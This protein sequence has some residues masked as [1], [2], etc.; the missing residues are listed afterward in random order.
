MLQGIVN[1][2]FATA[3]RLEAQIN[4]MEAKVAAQVVSQMSKSLVPFTQDE[5]HAAFAKRAADRMVEVEKKVAQIRISDVF[6]LKISIMQDG[7]LSAG[8]TWEDPAQA[9]QMAEML[10]ELGSKMGGA[11]QLAGAGAQARQISE[12]EFN[13][14]KE[15]GQIPQ[16]MTWQQVMADVQA[17]AKALLPLYQEMSKANQK[18][19]ESLPAPSQDSQEV[20]SYLQT[21][22]SHM[23]RNYQLFMP[24]KPPQGDDPMAAMM[25]MQEQVRPEKLYKVSVLASNKPGSGA[26]VIFEQKPTFNN[27][28]GKAKDASSISQQGG[29]MVKMETPGGPTLQSGSFIRANGGYLVLEL[30]DVLREPGVYQGLMQMIR[31]GKAVIAENGAMSMVADSDHYDVAAQVKVVLIG[32]P[33]LKMMLNQYDE[34][35]A[36]FFRATAEFESSLKIGAEAI[37]G[38][39]KFM[40]AMVEQ[41]GGKIYDFARGAVAGLFELAANVIESNE[42]LTAQFGVMRSIMLEASYWARQNGRTIVEREDLDMAID[43]R[44]ARKSGMARRIKEMYSSDTFHIAIEGK[45]VG[46]INGLAVMGDFGVPARIT[47]ENYVRPGANFLVSTDQAAKSTGNSFDKSIANIRGFMGRT[48]GRNHPVP[49]EVSISFEQNYGGIDGDSATQTMIYGM[50]SSLSGKPIKQGIAITGSTDQKGNV[51]VIGG[52]NHKIEGYFDVV[53]D[54]LKSEGR[55]LDGEQGIIIPTGN[56]KDLSLRPDIIEAVKAGKFTIYAVDHISQGV[57]ILMDTPYSEVLK[58]VEDRIAQVRSAAAS[59]SS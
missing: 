10:K 4:Q 14:L 47:F 5:A 59:E 2:I 17:Q 27:L 55:E 25:A 18:D 42:K 19:R 35:F 20:M 52:V 3:R 53:V 49:I 7:R 22:L 56:V 39:L 16:D 45:E 36:G 40:R 33:M 9:A 24:Q 34:D 38:Y 43:Q 11:V 28:F 15:A 48:F 6:G 37:S 50:L 54:K 21:L 1:E 29:M 41:S 44:M 32:S 57:E 26:P 13:Q 58:G 8:P 23:A 51:Q 31:N 30:K 12:K 46:Q